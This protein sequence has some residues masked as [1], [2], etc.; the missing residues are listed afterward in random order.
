MWPGMGV[1]EPRSLK[2]HPTRGFGLG[3]APTSDLG[4][5]TDCMLN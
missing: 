5:R 2:P 1:Q 4:G 3:E